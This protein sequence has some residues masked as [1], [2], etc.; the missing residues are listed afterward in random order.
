[1]AGLLELGAWTEDPSKEPGNFGDPA[2]LNQYLDAL[3]M[4]STFPGVYRALGCKAGPT[5]RGFRYTL[6]M[7]NREI[8][9]GRFAMFAAIGIIAAN[10]YTGKDAIEQF[11]A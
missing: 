4:R 9:N 1:M 7:R 8:N 11:G 10:V 2:G 3:I 6:E 5:C